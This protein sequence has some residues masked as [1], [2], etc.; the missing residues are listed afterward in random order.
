MH[1][2]TIQL[3]LQQKGDEEPVKSNKTVVRALVE[4][5]DDGDDDRERCL[6]EHVH[7]SKQREDQ[8]QVYVL[9]LHYF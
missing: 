9:Q 4:E 7:I 5:Q 8:P 1:H 3:P 2:A 6:E